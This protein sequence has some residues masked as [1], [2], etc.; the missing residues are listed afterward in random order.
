[1]HYKHGLN[2]RGNKEPLL[3]TVT[4]T[5]IRRL[6]LLLERYALNF[7]TDFSNRLGPAVYAR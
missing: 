4:I 3:P 6:M 5:G 2:G 1:M 7:K